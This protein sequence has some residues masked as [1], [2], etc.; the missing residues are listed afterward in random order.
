[1]DRRF[2]G[3]LLFLVL[4]MASV[5]L[6]GRL[7]GGG[8][9]R[10]EAN[11]RPIGESAQTLAVGE[12]RQIHITTREVQPLMTPRLAL[13]Y[14]VEPMSKAAFFGSLPSGATPPRFVAHRAEASSVVGIA[15]AGDPEALLILHDFQ[16]GQSWP[17]KADTDGQAQ[18]DARGR[19]LLERFEAHDPG[20]GFHL[21]RAQG[22]RPLEQLVDLS[23]P[24]APPASAAESDSASSAR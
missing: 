24:D 12:E 7:L 21:V 3:I 9:D 17:R 20:A 5:P 1:M 13:Y 15:A 6:V 11:P 10:G 14:K 19:R 23:D 2:I 8:D 16:T 18:L 4:V 22:L